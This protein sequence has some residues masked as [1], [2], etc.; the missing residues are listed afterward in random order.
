MG[1]DDLDSTH[2]M[3]GVNTIECHHICHLSCANPGELYTLRVRHTP[4][5]TNPFDKH[6]VSYFVLVNNEEQQSPWPTFADVPAGWRVVCG[7]AD[8]AAR[9]NHIE[10]NW[11]DIRPARL[12]GRLAK[13]SQS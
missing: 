6:E 13:G 2:G 10:R 4:M 3:P 8:R 9:L 7:E 11:T 5:D 1:R 12:R